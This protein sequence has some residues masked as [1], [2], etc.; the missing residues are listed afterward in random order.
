MSKDEVVTAAQLYGEHHDNCPICKKNSISL[1][2]EGR[3]LMENFYATL[4]NTLN[5]GS[6]RKENHK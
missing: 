2:K 6:P 3:I 1:C 5:K 4:Q